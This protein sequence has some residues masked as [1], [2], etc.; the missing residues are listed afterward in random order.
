MKHQNLLSH[1]LDISLIICM[2]QFA[3]FILLKICP[4]LVRLLGKIHALSIEVLK[5]G[6]TFKTLLHLMKV[7]IFFQ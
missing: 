2:K 6:L 7:T 1:D 5:L 4:D 3:Q